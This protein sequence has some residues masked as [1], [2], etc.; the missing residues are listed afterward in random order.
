MIV[1]KE[2]S[3]C[4]FIYVVIQGISQPHCGRDWKERQELCAC[5]G[6]GGLEGG[7]VCLWPR[8][9]CPRSPEV[10]LAHH[11]LL[12]LSLSLSLAFPFRLSLIHTRNAPSSSL[13]PTNTNL[14][15]EKN[16]A[17]RTWFV[18]SCWNSNKS[19]VHSSVSASQM[20]RKLYVGN[21][22][23]HVGRYIN[24]V[25]TRAFAAGG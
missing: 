10:F 3:A 9:V 4:E 13:S 6:R 24:R 18:V 23:H 14:V 16:V 11:T 21:S 7:G 12:S 20:S 1:R 22:K 15:G 2:E 8:R 25:S 19:R 5:W 17:H